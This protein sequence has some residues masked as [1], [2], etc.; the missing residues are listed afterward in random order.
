MQGTTHQKITELAFELLIGKTFKWDKDL[1]KNL[2]IGYSSYPDSVKDIEA[3]GTFINGFDLWGNEFTSFEHYCI[4]EDQTPKPRGYRGYNFQLDKSWGKIDLKDF[5]IKFHEEAWF[6]GLSSLFVGPLK[7]PA[8]ENWLSSHPM[9]LLLDNPSYTNKSFDEITYC[10]S[11]IVAE[12][13]EEGFKIASKINNLTYLGSEILASILHMA[14]DAC[15]FHHGK[16]LVLKGHRDYE[17]LMG[18]SLNDIVKTLKLSVPKR[19]WQGSRKEVERNAYYSSHGS[20]DKE[21]MR[22]SFKNAIESSAF[23]IKNLLGI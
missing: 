20:T 17:A 15:I 1:I 19:K 10:G 14:H 12:W 3:F 7:I 13:L 16:G 9:K 5:S 21:S 6:N 18:A 22:T 8:L 2:I 23:I 4:P 11:H